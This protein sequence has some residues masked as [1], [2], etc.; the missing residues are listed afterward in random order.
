M[1]A[2]PAGDPSS[3][4]TGGPPAR[5]GAPAQGPG[6]T[7]G[8]RPERP[9]E[10]PAEPG[11]PPEPEQPPEQSAEQTSEQ[12]PALAGLR[13]RKKQRT[14]LALLDAALDLFLSQGYEETTIDEIV[15]AVEVSQRT[16]FR[17]F[18]TKEDV[19]TGTLSEHDRL[20]KEALAA[21]PAGERPFTALFEALRVVLCAI[22]QGDPTDSARFRRVRQ[23]IESTPTLV[24]AHMA[25]HSA[26][27]DALVA[28]IARREGVDPVEDLRPRFVV[29]FFMAAAK[30]AFEDCARRDIWDAGTVA[31]RVE[32]SVALIGRTVREWV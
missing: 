29:A 20:L 12:G 14:R 3:P 17:Y 24:T 1:S 23:V 16:F 32:E 5:D 31:A 25:A 15:A 19:I 10:Q 21:R 4:E 11:R 6:K 8:Q 27:T 7:P 28:E 18:A 9:A 30:V 13:E 22:A 2:V 26:T